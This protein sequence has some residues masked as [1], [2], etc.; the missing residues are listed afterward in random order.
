MPEV[1]PNQ[2]TYI[3]PFSADT[4][5]GISK[6]LS[7]YNIFV[8]IG[9]DDSVGY[10]SRRFSSIFSDIPT[11]SARVYDPEGTEL[12]G[13]WGGGFTFSF[14]AGKVVVNNI[15]IEIGAFSTNFNEDSG[16][17][18]PAG[19]GLWSFGNTTTYATMCLMF[20]PYNNGV[21][22][23]AKPSAKIIY[24]LPNEV[25]FSIMAPICHVKI[26]KSGGIAQS[27]TTTLL[28]HSS[29]SDY[30]IEQIGFWKNFVIDGGDL[31]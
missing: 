19:F 23:T 26:I 12:I 1:I 30:P 6:V 17:W 9:D 7:P 14:T 11:V 15:L 8:K 5:D 28:E 13:T 16:H 18:K 2:V 31:G 25:D 24:A 21:V 29:I 22:D 3:S 4:P 10:N 27:G 20:D